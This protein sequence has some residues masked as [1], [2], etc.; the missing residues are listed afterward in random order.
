MKTILK[1]ITLFLCLSLFISNLNLVAQIFVEDII[2]VPDTAIAGIPLPLTGTVIPENATFQNIEW[3]IFDAGTTGATITG[4]T[5]HTDAEGT[6]IITAK[7]VESMTGDGF[8]KNFVIEVVES[9]G[10]NDLEFINIKIYPSP[11]SGELRIESGELRVSNVEMLD[12][13]GRKVLSSVSLSS[14][15][16]V[17][18]VSHLQAGIY[19]VRISSDIGQVVKKVVKQ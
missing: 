1:K 5:L 16:S 3:T 9:V 17:I 6:V 13:F 19:F 12:V 11:T 18:D 14:P 2:D 4:N 10:I 7:I 8:T 15:E